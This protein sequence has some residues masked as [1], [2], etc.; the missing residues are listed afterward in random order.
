MFKLLSGIRANAE[1]ARA[2]ALARYKAILEKGDDVTA[3]DMHL[4][5]SLMSELGKSA[6]DAEADLRIIA[7]HRRLTSLAGGEAEKDA[8]RQKATAEHNALS[9][10]TKAKMREMQERLGQTGLRRNNA[11]RVFADCCDA[12]GLLSALEMNNRELF[13]G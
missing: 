8:A 2:Q 13:N 10:D 3:A 11:E 4:L 9:A 12:K 6:A 7:E 1:K 5:Q